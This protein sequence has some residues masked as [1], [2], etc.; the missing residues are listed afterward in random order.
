MKKN[1]FYLIFFI[2]FFIFFIYFLIF[3]NILYFYNQNLLLKIYRKKN[4]II[5]YFIKLLNNDIKIKKHNLY[6]FLILI[7]LKKKL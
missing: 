5:F 1:N 4:R 2:C 6:S 3:L 7:K